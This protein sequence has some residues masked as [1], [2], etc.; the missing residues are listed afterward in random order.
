[1]KARF[2]WILIAS[3]ISVFGYGCSAKAINE[4]NDKKAA[5]I[6]NQYC[7][8]AGEKIYR[9]V[10]NVESVFIM[11][12]RA[13]KINFNDQFLL[14][15]PYGSDL[16]GDGYLHS[17]LR[18]YHASKRKAP[19]A[20]DIAISR[21]RATGYNFIEAVDA[22]DGRRYRYTGQIE[23]PW[24]T[25]KH[26]LKGYLRFSMKVVPGSANPPRYG[27]T[28]DDIS[29]QSDRALWIAGSSLRVIDLETGEVMAERVGYM[30]DPAQG[31]TV[32]GR[33]P[34]L[35]AAS[36][37]CP[38]FG[39]DHAFSAQSEQTVIFVEKVLHPIVE[40]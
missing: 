36:H 33:E 14:N 24:Q 35:M 31:S 30:Y 13:E 7:V 39:K 5:R 27:V 6:F 26:F 18:Q 34:W 11:R 23:E 1:M 20:K 29:T 25:D 17:F 32:G 16:L 28:Y 22:K 3:L 15:D 38:M 9:T 19:P 4:P 10:E 21:P 40:K 12:R 2:L 37:A 8:K